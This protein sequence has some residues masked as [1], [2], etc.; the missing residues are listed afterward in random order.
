MSASNAT[1]PEA[2]GIAPAQW[3]QIAWITVAAVAVFAFLRYLPTGTNLSHMD[4]RVD[5]KNS[6]EFCDPLNPQFIPVVAMRSPVSMTLT[7]AAAPTAQQSVACTLA[8]HTASGKPITPDDLLVAHTKKLHLLII[9]PTLRDYQHV[10]PA[11]TK[12][13]GE[14][15]FSFTPRTAGTYRVFADFTPTATARGLYASVDLVVSGTPVTGPASGP[16]PPE[17]FR[18]T[19]TPANTTL[20][21]GQTID[22]TFAG[23]RVD[24]GKVPLEPIMGAFAHLVAFDETR[25]GFAHLHPTE[26]DLSQPPD[27]TKP[28]LHFKVTIPRAGRYVIWAQVNLGGHEAFVPFWFNIGA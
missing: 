14:W 18:F 28:R 16:T 10:H 24:G 11:P 2:R 15:S 7:P 1:S 21:A 19:L 5:A 25:S 13:P 22:L 23:E 27:A 3:R 20:R 17:G 8:L 4:F 6:I 9:D 26:I 12:T